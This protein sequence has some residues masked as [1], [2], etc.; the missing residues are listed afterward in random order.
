MKTLKNFCESLL[1]SD[2]DITRADLFTEDDIKAMFGLQNSGATWTTDG[3]KL[4]LDAK[5]KYVDIQPLECKKRDINS[6]EI[7]NGMDMV[8]CLHDGPL[9]HFS[10][11]TNSGIYAD[12][13]E[14]L[15]WDHINIECNNLSFG[16]D[17]DNA[18][19]KLNHTKIKLTGMDAMLMFGAA[20]R[21]SIT[22]TCKFDGVCWLAFK[23]VSGSFGKKVSNLGLGEFK[24]WQHYEPIL[25]YEPTDD[26]FM[27]YWDIDP[28]KVL[29]LKEGKWPDLGKMCFTP[30]GVPQTKAP[31][32]TLYRLRK[33][34]TPISRTTKARVEYKGGWQGAISKSLKTEI[35]RL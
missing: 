15:N 5:R 12:V 1:D 10:I 4:I 33:T 24:S 7:I 20:S 14:A 32:T 6:V 29:G 9:D 26:E 19:I 21:L 31:C 27:Q 18:P 22:D 13:G 11:K 23:R 25:K 16:L 35:R 28:M 3:D 34:Y 17:D 8:Y 30:N 2:F